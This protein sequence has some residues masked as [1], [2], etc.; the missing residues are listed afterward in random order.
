MYLPQLIGNPVSWLSRNGQSRGTFAQSTDQ[1][2]G[3]DFWLVSRDRKSSVLHQDIE[4]SSLVMQMHTVPS[5]PD[6]PTPTRPPRTQSTMK[7]L[8]IKEPHNLN[9]NNDFNKPRSQSMSTTTTASTAI[10]GGPL[11]AMPKPLNLN[12]PLP[13]P[14]PS[15]DIDDA[16]VQDC[17][18][19]GKDT[20]R[21]SSANIMSVYK[22]VPYEDGHISVLRTKEWGHGT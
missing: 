10:L 18:E 16:I 8:E 2:Q 20:R 17:K 5:M 9:Y 13:I 6:M 22:L 12:K 1:K 4:S 19:K 15:L 11:S 21:T 14:R 7:S 3:P